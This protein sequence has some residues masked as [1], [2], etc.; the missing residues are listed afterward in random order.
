MTLPLPE[1]VFDADAGA[2]GGLGHLPEWDLSDLY[3][4]P[5]A[6]DVARDMDWLQTACR[7]FADD[8]EGRLATLDAAA[9]LAC[10]RRYER[11]DIIAG[12]LMSF[13]GLR[14]YQNTMDS[15]RAKFLGDTQQKITDFT[16]A[17]VFF[18]LEFNRLDDDRLADLL[19]VNADLARYRPVFERMRACGPT[20]FR[21]SWR[22]SS[23]TSRRSAPRPGTRS[24]T[25]PSPG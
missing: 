6:P 21:T 19:A 20:S 8:Y 23:T 13:A 2:Q 1:P 16:T 7:D 4:A 12:R 10:V 17:L 3:P 11:I 14:Y 9:M 24:S 25:R 22:S 18:G 5:D 15:A